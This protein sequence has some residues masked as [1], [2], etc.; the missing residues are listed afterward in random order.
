MERRNLEC[1][2][3]ISCF[4]P[5]DCECI[6]MVLLSSA[7]CLSV[8]RVNCGKTKE[9]SADILIPYERKIPL[10][11]RH[12]EL[13]LL[14]LL[15]LLGYFY[16]AK[17]AQCSKCA[18]STVMHWTRMSSV[19]FWT[20]PVICPVRAV[21]QEDCSTPRSLDSK[22]AVAIVRS[23]T[24]N[25]QSTRVCRSKLPAAEWWCWL[26]IRLK[27]LQGHAMLTLVRQ[28]CCLECNPLSNR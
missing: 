5:C 22:T 11:F 1:V 20:C 12:E 27:V 21:Q 23:S 3:H 6:R 26:A 17:I 8:K 16:S 4:L 25:S 13:L 15:L 24:W 2:K 9:S 10:V 18:S 7:V 14:L 28:D 19:C